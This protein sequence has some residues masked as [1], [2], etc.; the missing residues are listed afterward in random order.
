M[1]LPFLFPECRALSRTADLQGAKDPPVRVMCLP[2][3]GFQEV[4]VSRCS[5]VLALEVV[6]LP[7][8]AAVL[9]Q[10][11]LNAYSLP[12]TALGT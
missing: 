7:Q 5:A 11:I 8:Q 9:H 10:L 12:G 2:H 4:P 1:S 3:F 6:L